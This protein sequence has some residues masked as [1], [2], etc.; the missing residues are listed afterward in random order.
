MAGWES[1]DCGSTQRTVTTK[2]V[3]NL[4]TQGNDPGGTP[5]LL[6]LVVGSRHQRRTPPPGRIRT[7]RLHSLRP[8]LHGGFVQQYPGV[9]V[10]SPDFLSPMLL[11]CVE[12]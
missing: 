12:K 10:R 1:M 3:Q 11:A 5:G 7:R 8:W 9:L 6:N 4:M 2:R